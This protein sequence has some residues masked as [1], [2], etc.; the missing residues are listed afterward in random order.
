MYSALKGKGSPPKHGLIFQIPEI[1][2]APYRYRG[3]LARAFASKIVIAA[4]LD[5]FNG[6]FLGEKYRSE[7]RDFEQKLRNQNPENEKGE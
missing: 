4:R 2:N 5:E 6:E 1:G 3:K 7:L